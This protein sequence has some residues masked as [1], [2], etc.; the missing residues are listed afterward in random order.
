MG[1]SCSVHLPKSPAHVE[2]IKE[3]R[4]SDPRLLKANLH[5]WMC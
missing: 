4:A 2:A 5:K 3:N 1:I